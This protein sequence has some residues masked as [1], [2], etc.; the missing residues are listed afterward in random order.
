M[1]FFD[2][3]TIASLV[4]F[5]FL[6]VGCRTPSPTS[7]LRSDDTVAETPPADSAAV[8]A[9]AAASDFIGK[10]KLLAAHYPRSLDL[11][12]GQTYLRFMKDKVKP[13]L[14][15]V[16]VNGYDLTDDAGI[17]AAYNCSVQKV[18]GKVDKIGLD[19]MKS[20]AAGVAMRHVNLNN[21]AKAIQDSGSTISPFDAANFLGFASGG[22]VMIKYNDA[23]YA[24]NVHYDVSNMQSGRSY[25]VGPA[26]GANDASDR[27]YLD[28]VQAYTRNAPDNLP[29][30]YKTIFNSLLN[31]DASGYTQVNAEGQG[32]LSDF[33]AIYTAEEDRNLMQTGKIRPYWDAALL[34]VT[35]L[36]AFHA[37]QSSFGLYYFDLHNQKTAF[38][39]QTFKQTSCKLS[40]NTK[41]AALNDYWQYSRQW[42][43]GSTASCTRS[44]INLTKTEFRL[45]GQKITQWMRI[46]QPEV[47]NKVVGAMAINPAQITD[48]LNLYYELSKLLISPR[49]LEAFDNADAFANAWLDFIGQTTVHANDIGANFLPTTAVTPAME[50]PAAAITPDPQDGQMPNTQQAGG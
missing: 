27:E 15:D 20:T 26:K 21:I 40:T 36:A 29:A 32:V 30:F 38:A 44:G 9:P 41:P 49:G 42:Q 5:G 23:N 7:H 10:C 34:E 43:H 1:R 50:M 14:D 11:T 13:M 6:P 24:L 25:G 17:D 4:F 45:L 48:K 39:T 12:P 35:L 28:E 33:L 16:A 8:V 19:L 47:F 2:R 22:G 37:G 3:S 18:R 31:S 46:N